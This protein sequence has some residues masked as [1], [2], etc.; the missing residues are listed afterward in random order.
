MDSEIIVAIDLGTQDI[1]GV[2]GTKNEDNV[3]SILASASVPSDQSVRRGLIHNIDKAGAK[4]KQLVNYLENNLNGRKIAKAY[5]TISGQSLH[6]VN[7]IERKNLSSSGIVTE[8]VIAQ[9]KKEVEKN[10]SD[11]RAKYQIGGVEY[12]VDSKAEVNPVGVTC[13]AIEGKFK[14][15]EGRP[16]LYT[17]TEKT[18]Q[19]AG[20]DIAGYMI[21]I[22]STADIALTEDEKELGCALIDFGSGTTTVAIYKAG[23]FQYMATI[24]FGG[25]N[26]TKDISSLNFTENEAE[27]YKK[28]YGKAK[29]KTDNNV[30]SPFSNKNDIDLLELNKV[31]VL[32]LDEIIANIK[33]QI[34]ISGFEDKLG[35]GIIVTGGASQLKELDN[36]LGEKFEMPVRLTSALRST[37]NNNSKIGDDPCYTEVLGLLRL[38]TIDCAE[39]IVEEL[40]DDDDDAINNSDK[41]DSKNIFNDF[42]R[43]SKSN[44]PKSDSKPKPEKEKKQKNNGLSTFFDVL[45]KEGEDD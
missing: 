8:N 14:V 35:A 3:V 27:T 25:R 40:D 22:L 31:I 34:K 26:L 23:I 33:E 10:T 43:K 29:V 12:F 41:K 32:R 36:Y 42:W 28:S 37:V 4:V 5:V 1:K 13:S 38:G 30:F 45:F 44:L 39:P 21:G 18:F 16:N 20:I 17:I 19:K 6:S 2:V 15:I 9:L 24:P 11:M 7:Y